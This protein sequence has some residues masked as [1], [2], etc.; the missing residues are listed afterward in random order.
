M[1]DIKKVKVGDTLLYRGEGIVSDGVELFTGGK[2]SHDSIVSKIQDDTVWIIESHIDTGVVEKILN[3]KWYKI[4]DIYRYNGKLKKGQ[5][6]KRIQWLRS[7]IGCKYGLGDFPAAF[8]HSV[9]GGIFHLPWLRKMKPILNNP[10][11]YF[12]SELDATS[13]YK[14][15]INITPK[16]HY[17]NTTPNDM[18]KSKKL[19][20]VA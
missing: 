11:R 2:Y 3:P 10:D 4:I 20:R 17:M 19:T 6:S 14:I 15:G 8:I 16:V 12:C 9:I 5:M 1:F 18:S 13:W 7:K